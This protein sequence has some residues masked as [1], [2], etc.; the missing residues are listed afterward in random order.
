MHEGR[1]DSNQSA[2]NKISQSITDQEILTFKQ[3][4]SNLTEGFIHRT[5]L[6]NKIVTHTEFASDLVNKV[7]NNNGDRDNKQYLYYQTIKLLGRE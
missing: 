1:S 5:N 4:S 7:S 3:E 6:A 2:K